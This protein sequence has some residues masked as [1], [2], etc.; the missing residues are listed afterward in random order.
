METH[1]VQRV[2]GRYE[3]ALLWKD[4][5]PLPFNRA[6]AL[7]RHRSFEKKLQRDPELYERV[8]EL[9]RSHLKNGYIRVADDSCGEDGRKWFLP[10]FNVHNPAKPGKVRLVFD[11]AAKFEGVSLNDRLLSG[12]DLTAPL[13]MVLQQFRTRRIGVSGDLQDMYHRVYIRE[14]DRCS[15]KFVW[16]EHEEEPLLDYEMCVLTFGATCSPSLAQYVKNQHAERYRETH[17]AAVEAICGD[18]YVDDWLGGADTEE[19]TLQL[20]LQVKWIHE[21]A[22]FHMHKWVSNSRIVLSGLHEEQPE[23]EV[24][25]SNS[26]ILGMKWNTAD[27]SLSFLFRHTKFREDLLNGSGSPTK[28]EMLK[29][30]MSI[31]DPLG[32]V[33]FLTVEARLILREAWREEADW[34]DELRGGLQ[35]RW[36]EWTSHLRGLSEISIPR[37]HG[38][39]VGHVDLHVFVDA[40]EAAIS[41]VC[42][43][44]QNSGARVIS[45]LCMAKCLVA[46][47]KTK[48][49]PRLELDAAVLGTRVAEMVK[50][51]WTVNRIVY[52]SDARDVIWWINCG[53]RR[54][55][56]YVANRVA[57]I[58][59]VSEPGQWRWTPTDQNPADW[60]TKWADRTGT[61]RLWWNGPE[62]LQWPEEQ[63]PAVLHE[64]ERLLELKPLLLVVK[65][66]AEGDEAVLVPDVNRFSKWT[67]FLN[68]TAYALKFCQI[69]KKREYPGPLGNIDRQRAEVVIFKEV[70]KGMQR[71]KSM[72]EFLT[73]VAPFIDQDGV[74]RMRGRAARSKHLPFDARFPIIVREHPIVVLLVEFYHRLNGHQNTTTVVN[75]LR[76][77]IVMPH[78]RAVVKRVISRCRMCCVRRAAPVVPQMSALPT[79]RM[80]LYMPPFSYTGVDCF[81]V[82]DAAKGRSLFSKS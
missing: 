59:T 39:E 76:Q 68:A 13:V 79:C 49:I 1:T 34:D 8:R 44:V 64:P 62:F 80:A 55:T 74:L 10:V 16:R 7:Q 71:E 19:E 24:S 78:L 56:P 12:P 5:A 50:K 69:L 14:E 63:W 23:T 32:L 30:V 27:D 42:Y 60:G 37:W 51:T 73:S 17:Q 66:H 40:S 58:L 2:D 28:R 38:T 22:G 65:K 15:Q 21:Q 67:V 6:M 72:R 11:C 45:N 9:M 31:Y 41:A 3:T 53:K 43:V 36:A 29:V 47:L 57:A 54:Y 75:E 61:E 52:W 81:V 20:A 25:L 46:P 26:A 18:H 77:K 70:Q 48:S 82:F 4:D 35:R 33:S